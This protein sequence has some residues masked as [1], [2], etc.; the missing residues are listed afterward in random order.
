M[1]Y[2]LWYRQDKD[3]YAESDDF[4]G[5][6]SEEHIIKGLV[7]ATKYFFKLEAVNSLGECII[8]FQS[9]TVKL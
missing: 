1:N 9:Q 4:I 6:D 8:H 7:P 3:I 5:G 2:T